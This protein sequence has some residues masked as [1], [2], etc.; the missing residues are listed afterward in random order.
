MSIDLAQVHKVAHLARLALTPAE[1]AQFTQQLNDI[2][3]YVEQISELDLKDVPP[4]TR[5]IDVANVT[6]PD[7]H[8]PADNREELLA[9]APAQEGDF[10]RVPKI[11]GDAD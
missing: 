10:F 1:E 3:G 7:Q 8:R 2:L 6:R 9:A 5:A 4:T 11:L